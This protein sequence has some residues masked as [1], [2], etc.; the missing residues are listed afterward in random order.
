M[1]VPADSGMITASMISDQRLNTNLCSGNNKP[2]CGLVGAVS[3]ID[4]SVFSNQLQSLMETLQGTLTGDAAANIIGEIEKI[5]QG[6][7]A[8]GNANKLGGQLPNHYTKQTDFSDYKTKITNGTES[9]GRVCGLELWQG[10]QAQ[11]DAIATKDIT[12]VYFIKGV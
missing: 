7:T 4:T 12:T 5:K 9:V 3:Q 10:T 6:V 8:V 2:V 11:F 1:T